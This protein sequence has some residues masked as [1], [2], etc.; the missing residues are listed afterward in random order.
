[1]KNSMEYITANTNNST[2]RINPLIRGDDTKLRNNLQNNPPANANKAI[3]AN[4]LIVKQP[5]VEILSTN[6]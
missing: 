5:V 1:M 2:K 6:S 4:D 3:I